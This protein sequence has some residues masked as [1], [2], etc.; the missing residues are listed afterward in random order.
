MQQYTGVCF[1]PATT[2][3]EYCPAKSA[4]KKID[5]QYCKP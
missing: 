2:P 5:L 4:I 1:L 3:Q